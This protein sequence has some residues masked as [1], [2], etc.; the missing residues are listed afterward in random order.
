[1]IVGSECDI[2]YAIT[3][4]EKDNKGNKSIHGG[5]AWSI[6]CFV[7]KCIEFVNNNLRSIESNLFTFPCYIYDQNINM[8]HQVRYCRNDDKVEFVQI[9][10]VPLLRELDNGIKYVGIGT[11]E[12][13]SLGISAIKQLFEDDFI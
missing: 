1:M 6:W 2:M 5:T 4:F 3:W 12:L 10:K 13:N 9:E 7:T 11:R 8:W